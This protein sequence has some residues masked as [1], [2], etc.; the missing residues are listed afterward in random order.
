MGAD[1]RQDPAPE[2]LRTR[3]GTRR[4]A[5]PRI[6]EVIDQMEVGPDEAIPHVQHVLDLVLQDIPRHAQNTLVLL[7]EENR[8]L[9]QIQVLCPERRPRA[10][11]PSRTVYPRLRHPA[12]SIL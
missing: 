1:T 11:P 10:S 4:Q 7:T 2:P 5:P 3:R 8:L 12:S 9:Q 6:A